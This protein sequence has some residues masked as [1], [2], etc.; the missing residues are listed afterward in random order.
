[1]KRIVLLALFLAALAAVFVVV[2]HAPET[3]SARV[4]VL[5]D[6]SKNAPQNGIPLFSESD[7][8]ELTAA[9]S[10]TGGEIGFGVIRDRDTPLARVVVDMGGNAYQNQSRRARMNG[11]RS[12]VIEKLSARLSAKTAVASAMDR[13]NTFFREN[14]PGS[15]QY[16]ILITDSIHDPTRTPPALPA[17]GV[18]VLVVGGSNSRPSLP[19]AHYFESVSAAIN[20]ITVGDPANDAE[21]TEDNTE[22]TEAKEAKKR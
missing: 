18:T 16:L 3:H 12:E 14:H 5:Q 17:D 6:L 13:A 9:V 22:I 7:F 11:F 8:K 15:R 19:G 21:T 1:M 4:V 20:S 10:R 2:H